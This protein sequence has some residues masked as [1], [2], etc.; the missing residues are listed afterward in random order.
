MNRRLLLYLGPLYSPR[1]SCPNAR[2]PRRA[3]PACSQP[4]AGS[5]F[6]TVAVKTNVPP[7]IK[8]LQPRVGGAEPPK[9]NCGVSCAY[10]RTIVL[11][12]GLGVCQ[13]RR[14]ARPALCGAHF[15]PS[16]L[17]PLYNLHLLPADCLTHPLSPTNV[18]PS[19]PTSYP[20]SSPL[21][22]H[23]PAV[24][25]S[26]TV[27]HQSHATCQRSPATPSYAQAT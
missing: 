8:W 12:G 27:S 22:S 14:G 7:I 25:S 16:S 4:I 5:P 6:S 19:S 23:L 1:A 11:F 10:G 13:A 15:S 3:R 21:T 17:L 2:L 20:H 24:S 26:V 18:Q 9:F